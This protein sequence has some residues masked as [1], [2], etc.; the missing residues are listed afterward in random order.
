MKYDS[1]PL[2]NVRVHYDANTGAVVLSSKDPAIKGK[3]FQI[4]LSADSP[5]YDTLLNLLETRGLAEVNSTKIAK[6]IGIP[7]VKMTDSDKGEYK[8]RIRIGE[9]FED[10]PIELDLTHS[11]H[12][13]IA[14]GTGSG[15][16]IIQRLIL[17]HALSHRD[18][19]EVYGIDL[20]RVELSPYFEDSKDNLA[21]TLDGS[22]K[23][24]AS[25]KRELEDRYSFLETEGKNSYQD[26]D[27]KAIYLVIDELSPISGVGGVD[28]P[29]GRVEDAKRVFIQENLA[30][31]TRLGRAAG[32]YLFV[33]TQRPDAT[34]MSGEF[35]ANLTTRI[36]A[37]NAGAAVAH[38]TLD[39]RP[40]FG[41]ALLRNRGRAIVSIYGQQKLI[42]V[43][44]LEHGD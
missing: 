5:T 1:L 21:T 31:L 23:L 29:E 42:Q 20:K 7:S 6:H 10:E 37:G 25:L 8:T 39:K 41:G 18:E 4:K 11:P 32:I 40:A 26:T 15:K 2:E 43:Y 3:P 22:L 13:L 16:S 30:L 14:G 27:L 38:L 12:T 35:K 44:Y 28:S 24:L 36:L 33:A 17:A 19:I 9:S 34:V